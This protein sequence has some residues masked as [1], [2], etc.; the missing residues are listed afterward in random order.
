MKDGGVLMLEVIHAVT[1]G[2]VG[3]T[4]IWAL[5]KRPQALATILALLVAPFPGER[6]YGRYKEMAGLP[7]TEESP[8]KETPQK[9][10]KRGK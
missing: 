3:M 1:G 9:K 8:T 5:I 7:S 6:T 2:G 4:L 10:A